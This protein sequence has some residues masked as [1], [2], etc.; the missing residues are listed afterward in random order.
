[1]NRTYLAV[2]ALL[3][4]IILTDISQAATGPIKVISITPVTSTTYVNSADQI[5]SVI[6]TPNSIVLVGTIQESGTSKAYVRALDRFGVQSWE[7]ILESTTEGIATTAIRDAAGNINVIGVTAIPESAP[8]PLPV[9][10]GGVNPSGFVLETTTSSVS[11]LKQLSVWRIN[12]NGGLIDSHSVT[13]DYVLFPKSALLT[14]GKVKI[15]GAI[16]SHASDSFSTTM[17]DLGNFTALRISSVKEIKQATLTIVK[18][19][20]SIWKSFISSGAIQGLPSWKPKIATP[21]LI[22][23]S[24]KTGAVVS[25]YK[26]IGTL[27]ALIW[28]SAIGIVL[29]ADLETGY[30][31]NIIK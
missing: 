14:S 7:L 13:S 28:E 25:A 9:P 8:P 26:Y 29:V 20:R 11:Q 16:S 2:L 3:T 24:L 12:A 19:S 1:M 22:R 4:S 31:V 30:T 23:Y 21:V 6:T 17:D 27:T 5:S 10:A 18:S 15:S